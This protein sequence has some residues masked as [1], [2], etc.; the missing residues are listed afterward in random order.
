MGERSW[1]ICGSIVGSGSIVQTAD[2]NL[3]ACRTRAYRP[4]REVERGPVPSCEDRRQGVA[5]VRA[6][7]P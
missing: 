6:A 7:G 1:E 2:A 5:T 4:A 3:R